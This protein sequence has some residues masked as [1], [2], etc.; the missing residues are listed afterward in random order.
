MKEGAL[1]TLCQVYTAQNRLMELITPGNDISW[2]SSE[3]EEGFGK[4]H[5]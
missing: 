2:T 1:V 5:G 4:I 3:V